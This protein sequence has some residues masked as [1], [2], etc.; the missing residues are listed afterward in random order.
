V[1]G[2]EVQGPLSISRET[3]LGEIS[4]VPLGADG[5]TSVTVTASRRSAMNRIKA[6]LAQIAA[7]KYSADEIDKMS[8]EEAKAALKNAMDDEPDGDE[9]K[10]K[11]EDDK[12]KAE[13]D[14][15]M[16]RLCRYRLCRLNR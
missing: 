10:A 16:E 14:D 7:G 6:A 8:E 11:A 1:N 15:D 5:D 12:E 13:A 3:E 2:R 9:T 4:F